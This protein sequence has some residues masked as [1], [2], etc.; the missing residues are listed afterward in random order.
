MNLKEYLAAKNNIS[1][2]SLDPIVMQFNLLTGLG[3]TTNMLEQ[4][5][6]PV[7]T[8]NKLHTIIQHRLWGHSWTE[9]SKHT[10]QHSYCILLRTKAL[11]DSVCIETTYRSDKNDLTP[12]DTIKQALLLLNLLIEM[13]SIGNNKTATTWSYHNQP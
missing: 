9:Q 10:G 5:H 2:L 3:L 8:L 1:Q 6:Q 7:G 13:P 12:A 11:A 4:L